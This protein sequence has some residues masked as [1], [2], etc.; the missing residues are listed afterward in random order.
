GFSPRVFDAIT[1]GIVR[2]LEEAHARLEPA[3]LSLGRVRVPCAERVAF[4]RSLAAYLRNPEVRGAPSADRALDRTLTLVAAHDARGRAI[5]ALAL[6]AL[7]ATC[8]HG[9]GQRLHPDWPG[10][11]AK[12]LEARARARGASSDFVAIFGQ[13][14]A[15][16]ASPSFRYD[17]R[18]GFTIGAHD[19]DEDAAAYVARV[20]SDAASSL[21]DG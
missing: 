12:R 21:L 1:D 18:R 9:D 2:A 6:F 3:R 4:N 19:A 20:L 11:A 7:H 14:A 13:G 15:G 10:L 17:A 16:D 5:G 8:I